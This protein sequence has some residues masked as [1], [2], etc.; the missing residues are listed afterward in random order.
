[1]AWKGSFK[2]KHPEKYVGDVKNIVYRSSWEL[3][4]MSELDKH[5]DVLM[6][7]SEECVVPYF[8]P[9]S[10]RTRRYFPDFIIK[11]KNKEG[12]VQ[13]LMVEIKPYHETQKPENTAG[14]SRR[15]FLK[16]AMTYGKNISKWKA[17]QA[18]CLEK[19]WLFKVLTERELGTAITG[20]YSK[21]R[22]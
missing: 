2:P 1:M 13:T 7:S 22:K 21:G 9:T 20:P 12:V 18:Y 11:R 16:E 6:W 3:R 14:K 17:A 10:N 19:G 15:R 4:F 5:P 8:D